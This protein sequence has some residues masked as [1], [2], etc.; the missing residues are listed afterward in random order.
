MSVVHELV[1]EV[2]PEGN[3]LSE[4][5]LLRGYG[6]APSLLPVPIARRCMCGVL[7]APAD[8]DAI[9]ATVRAHNDTRGHDAW[10]RAA[11]RR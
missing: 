4:D 1:H 5:A 6:E 9:Q 2:R 3:R 8:E 10:A 11:G 7:I